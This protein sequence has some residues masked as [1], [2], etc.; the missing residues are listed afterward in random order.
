MMNVTV[1]R[2]SVSPVMSGSA[3]VT[4]DVNYQGV[5]KIVLMDMSGRTVMSRTV[6]V[7]PGAN[8]FTVDRGTLPSGA[9]FI[10][11]NT[12][13]EHLQSRVLAQ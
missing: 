6:H 4:L 9:Y 2:L 7:V 8:E 1:S 12:A 13:F 3:R 10:K 11:V 5:A